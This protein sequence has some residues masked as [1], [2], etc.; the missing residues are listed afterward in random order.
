MFL[1]KCLKSPKTAFISFGS[2]N[3]WLGVSNKL[4]HKNSNVQTT[5]LFTSIVSGMHYP[6]F[7]NC[8]D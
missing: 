6:K 5:V 8:Q 2:G 3:T 1:I 4:Q 7:S